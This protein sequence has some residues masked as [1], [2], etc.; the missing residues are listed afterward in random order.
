MLSVLDTDSIIISMIKKEPVATSS[1]T[2]NQP[3]SKQALDHIR[4]SRLFA[5]NEL[6]NNK[7]FSYVMQGRR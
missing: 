5:A 7:M 6:V 3:P 4:D 2:T 1:K